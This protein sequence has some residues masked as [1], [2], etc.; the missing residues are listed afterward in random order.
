[1]KLKKLECNPFISDKVYPFSFLYVEDFI[2]SNFKLY[3]LVNDSYA[4]LQSVI[5]IV[6]SIFF[7]T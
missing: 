1:M 5:S 2:C 7:F 3:F 6:P 4:L